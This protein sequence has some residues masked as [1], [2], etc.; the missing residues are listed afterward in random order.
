MT[1]L[2]DAEREAHYSIDIYPKRDITIVKGQGATVYDEAGREYIDCAAGIGVASVGHANPRVVAAI[3]EQASQL[4]TCPGIFNNNT[5]ADL[6]ELLV[7]VAPS[8]LTRAFL[9]NSGTEAVEAALKFARHSTGRSNIISTMR[10]YH[11]RTMGALAATHKKEY[12]EPF[13]PLPGG[14][15]YVPYNNADKLAGAMDDQTAAVIVEVV[16]GEGGIR[17]ATGEYLQRVRELCDEH[18]ALL[19]VDE[20][21]TGFCRTGRFFGC[22]HFNLQPDIM[23]IAKA[24]AGG[25]PMGAVLASDKVA[26][27]RGLHG[28]TFGGNPLSCA[29]AI[30]AIGFMRDEGLAERAATLG[31]RFSERFNAA[32]P[33]CVRDVRQLGLM[34]G[35]ELKE[36][37]QPYIVA[38]MDKGILALP[39]GPTVLRLL[40]P[41]V[42]SE[43]QIDRV[44]DTLL[45]VLSASESAGAA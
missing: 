37:V 40:P 19:I 42:I 10:G 4:I 13:Q 5:R 31:S 36:R 12:R 30:A 18:G 11:G 41:L 6:L 29:A 25:V 16:Q 9:C 1:T 20:V 17:P 45:E 23:C 24:M 14:F 7:S 28:S 43:E 32:R 2:T 15:S 27:L 38:L 35:I 26:P 34:I 8:S 44:A 3:T 21:Q 22:D 33:A 39:A